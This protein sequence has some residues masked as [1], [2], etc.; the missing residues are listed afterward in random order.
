MRTARFTSR[1]E[2]D[3]VVHQHDERI[4]LREFL[5]LDDA[6]GGVSFADEAWRGRRGR[7]DSSNSAGLHAHRPAGVAAG[8][9]RRARLA[10]APTT[11]AVRAIQVSA[12]DKCPAMPS[13]L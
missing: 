2:I 3:S 9:R 4:V 1:L 6:D 11:P 10:N 7:H 13:Q 5:R 12:I 8:R